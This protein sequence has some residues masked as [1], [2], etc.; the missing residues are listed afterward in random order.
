M[1]EG[2]RE[3]AGGVFRR[4]KKEEG[5]PNPDMSVGEEVSSQSIS[6]EQPK[7]TRAEALARLEAL[8][9]K[10][11][12]SATTGGSSGSGKPHRTSKS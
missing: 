6:S 11:R 1:A 4:V 8:K 9:N 10:S 7:V 5:V 2:R 3:I 12:T